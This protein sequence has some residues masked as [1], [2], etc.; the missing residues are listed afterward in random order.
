VA[1][2]F[3]AA[4]L[5]TGLALFRCAAGYA[6][7][8][9]QRISALFGG[10]FA[11]S[12]SPR[13]VIDAQRPR[14][15]DRFRELNAAL[16]AARSQ[17]PVPSASG[18]F[19][20]YWNPQF[21]SFVRAEE[22]LGSNIAERAHTLGLHVVTLSVSYTRVDFDTL[23]GD[24]LDRLRSVQ[25]ALSQGFLNQLP[26]Q[27][28]TR[29]SDDLLETHLNMSFGFDLIFFSAAFGLTDSIDVSAALA[30]NRAR[31]RAGA[32]AMIQDPHG[33]GGATFT[34]AQ[35]GVIVGG[36]GVCS[37]DFRCAQDSFDASAFGTGD[38]FLRTKWHVGDTAFADLAVAGTLTVP[39]GN[40]DDLLGFH[41]PTLMPW[42]IASKTFGRVSP[43]LNLGY[44]LRGGQDAPSQAQWIAGADLRTWDWLTLA[45]DFV[46][47]HDDKR[48]GVN[49]DVLQSAVGFKVNPFGNLVI[50]G[51]FQFPLNRDG[52]RADV[53]YSGQAEYTF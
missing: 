48:D 19:Q 12:I 8:L 15:A 49:D 7:P 11:T 4:V 43:H 24:H 10:V 50:A 18:A 44:A 6:Q 33:D 45:A 2:R 39:T 25:P 32:Q 13:D 29:A 17:A 31:M 3:I 26:L 20:F 22:S 38:L 16:A 37:T 42:L 21:D 14:V 53:I 47:F 51:T 36:S 9:D 28:R 52:L 5:L 35:K 27:D 34:I 30:V 46:G 1:Y 40:A 23:E 41:N